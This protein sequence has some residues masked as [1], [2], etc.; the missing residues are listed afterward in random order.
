[1]VGLKREVV[2][3]RMP[4]TLSFGANWG[5]GQKPERVFLR[6]IAILLLHRRAELGYSVVPRRFFLKA[7][8]A[9]IGWY[10]ADAFRLPAGVIRRVFMFQC[11]EC[12]A[13]I[14]VDM[15]EV[16]EG[17]IISC[18]ECGAIL[19]VVSI[20]PPELELDEEGDGFDE[21]EEEEESW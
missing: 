5:R 15:D 3:W 8:G 1:L 4:K 14:D 13:D 21:D 9:G 17:D 7:Q 11:T 19:R 6:R 2:L 16:D 18:D 10:E 20:T 12:G